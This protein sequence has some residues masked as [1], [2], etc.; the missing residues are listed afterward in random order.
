M[1]CVI[2]LNGVSSDP[3]KIGKRLEY[4]VKFSSGNYLVSVELE[5]IWPDQNVAF[6]KCRTLGF[7]LDNGRPQ[8]GDIIG[9]NEEDIR[10][11]IL[12]LDPKQIE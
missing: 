6:G 8:I 3:G 9:M 10:G 11:W 7:E 12:C 2:S 4:F 1:K 5:C